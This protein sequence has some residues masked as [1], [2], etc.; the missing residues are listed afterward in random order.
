[1]FQEECL[2]DN[3]SVSTTISRIFCVLPS[4]RGSLLIQTDVTR[5]GSLTDTKAAGYA[6]TVL[7]YSLHLIATILGPQKN[8][9]AWA[10][11]LA[12]DASTHYGRSYLD[13]CIRIHIDGKLHNFHLLA[14][15]MYETH[16]GENMFHLVVRVLD[17]VC[18]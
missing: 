2:F 8:R 13:N 10:F 5:I 14:I 9:S 7:A 17:I 15:P 4:K 18:P 16:T 1:M 11:S 3:V 12:N 6:R